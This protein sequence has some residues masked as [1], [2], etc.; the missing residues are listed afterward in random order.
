MRKAAEQGDR[1]GQRYLAN[2]YML[3]PTEDELLVYMWLDLAAAQGARDAA[4]ARDQVAHRLWTTGRIEEAKKLVE[5]WRENH[6][7]VEAQ[8]A[9]VAAPSETEGDG[10]PSCLAGATFGPIGEDSP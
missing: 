2:N 10:T 4:A 1:W 8:Y 7:F 6:T 9:A 3:G 5:E